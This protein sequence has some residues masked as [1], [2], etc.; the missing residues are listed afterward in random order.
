MKGNMNDPVFQSL[1]E[2]SWRGKLSP[3]DQARLRAWLAAHPE[4]EGEWRA[5]AALNDILHRLPEAPMSSNFTS[6]V[7]QAVAAEDA[8][9]ARESSWGRWWEGFG[10]LFVPKLG[11]A[12]VLVCLGGV[13]LQQY[14]QF[15]RGHIARDLALI[16]MSTTMPAPEILQDFESIQ[17]FS[18]LAYFTAAPAVSDEDLLKALE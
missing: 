9:R 4:F 12:L 6:R 14:R 15:N 13:A 16:P 7:M 17:E 10:R 11:W 1:L 2:A 3:D 18:R 5:E 8:R